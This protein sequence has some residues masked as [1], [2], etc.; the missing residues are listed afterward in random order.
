MEQYTIRYRAT[1]AHGRTA[2]IVEDGVRAAYVY[3]GGGLQVSLP[4]GNQ[5]D[6]TGRLA[7]LLAHQSVVV[8]VPSAASYSLDGLRRVAG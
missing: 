3:C 7:A 4:L 2:L 6:A 5:D 8:A 1:N